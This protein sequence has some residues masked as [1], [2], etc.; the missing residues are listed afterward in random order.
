MVGV[1][2]AYGGRGRVWGLLDAKL[3]KAR[4]SWGTL[5]ENY[6]KLAGICW[7]LLGLVGLCWALQGFAW[8][9]WALLGFVGF[10]WLLLGFAGLWFKLGKVWES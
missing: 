7:A 1:W 3:G 8:L 9:C 2:W 6:K 5:G 4:E 10:Y